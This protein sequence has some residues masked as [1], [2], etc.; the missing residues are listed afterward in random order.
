MRVRRCKTCGCDISHRY[1]K[2]QRCLKCAAERAEALTRRRRRAARLR[3]N[4]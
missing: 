1:I 4:D 3:S 2:T